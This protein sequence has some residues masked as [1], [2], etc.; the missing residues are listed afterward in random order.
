MITSNDSTGSDI[1][2]FFAGCVHAD[3]TFAQKSFR[4]W[5][6]RAQS[7]ACLGLSWGS[8]SNCLYVESIRKC[9]WLPT[10]WFVC[11]LPNKSANFKLTLNCRGL[12][13]GSKNETSFTLL[14]ASL[15]VAPLFHY[16]FIH[17]AFQFCLLAGRNRKTGWLRRRRP[18]SRPSLPPA[19]PKISPL[20]APRP[21]KVEKTKGQ[22]RGNK[23][24]RRRQLWGWKD[25]ITWTYDL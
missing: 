15:W 2:F 8:I 5:I 23:R 20:P 22:T 24:N 3:L 16:L 11:P 12:S 9:S 19:I 1:T 13:F 6:L 14:V 25:K 18:P 21:L 4:R 17:I 7:R 10:C